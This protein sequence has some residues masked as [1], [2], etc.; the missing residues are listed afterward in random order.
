MLHQCGVSAV[1]EI[2]MECGQNIPNICLKPYIV[3]FNVFC[4]PTYIS[5]QNKKLDVYLFVLYLTLL[6]KW[7]HK[8]KVLSHKEVKLLYTKCY[9]LCSIFAAYQMSKHISKVFFTYK[10]QLE[11]SALF[12]THQRLRWLISPQKNLPQT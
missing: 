2:T 8:S 12:L 9:V 11:A 7:L 1:S 10:T 6:Q 4:L 3:S 5:I